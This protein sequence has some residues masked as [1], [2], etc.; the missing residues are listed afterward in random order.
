MLAWWPC[1]QKCLLIFLFVQ[2]WWQRPYF[3]NWGY[4]IFPGAKSS[5][6]LKEQVVGTF[7]SSFHWRFRNQWKGR[8]YSEI[9]ESLAFILF[10]LASFPLIFLFNGKGCNEI[11]CS[12]WGSPDDNIASCVLWCP[13]LPLVR[14]HRECFIPCLSKLK[15]IY[16][17]EV[18]D[19]SCY[20][21]NKTGGNLDCC[22][23]FST[24]IFEI[25]WDVLSSSCWDFCF[26]PYLTLSQPRSH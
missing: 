20:H 11:N 21:G 13:L 26:L 18:V 25:W 22:Q 5:R 7:W 16:Q 4:Q 3:K 19:C 12:H 24:S 9:H 15:K 1:I 23:Y 2:G 8:S 10:S 17:K 6:T 14:R